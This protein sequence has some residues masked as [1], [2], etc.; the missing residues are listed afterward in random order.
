VLSATITYTHDDRSRSDRDRTVTGKAL[1]VSFTPR[2]GSRLT[3]VMS[4][5]DM[6]RLVKA[7]VVMA[8]CR[9]VKAYRHGPTVEVTDLVTNEVHALRASGCCGVALA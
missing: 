5:E 7:G 1:T 4:D 3:L 6:T 8:G 9:H 2:S